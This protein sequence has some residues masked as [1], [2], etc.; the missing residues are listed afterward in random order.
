MSMVAAIKDRGVRQGNSKS[1]HSLSSLKKGNE[2]LTCCPR[3]RPAHE[4]RKIVLG[5]G[6]SWIHLNFDQR[7]YSMPAS[8]FHSHLFESSKDTPAPLGATKSVF[9]QR[10]WRSL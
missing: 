1:E 8:R 3:I 2:W 5:V 9:D 7:K 10:R 6:I 4:G